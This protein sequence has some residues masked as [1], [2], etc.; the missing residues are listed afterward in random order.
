MKTPDFKERRSCPVCGDCGVWS[1]GLV[2]H[3]VEEFVA[4]VDGVDISREVKYVHVK[5]KVLDDDPKKSQR[6]WYMASILKNGKALFG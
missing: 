5:L 1:F 4:V 2:R 3:W 6:L